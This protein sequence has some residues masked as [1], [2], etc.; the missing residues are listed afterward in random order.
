MF[1]KDITYTDFNGD[2]DVVL[3]ETLRFAYT[4]PAVRLYERETG[5]E[6]FRDYDGAVRAFSAAL[7][8]VDLGQLKKI[9]VSGGTLDA[10]NAGDI[11]EGIDYLQVLTN[12]EIN[13]FMLKLIPCL[14]AEAAGGVLV[15]NEETHDNAENAPWFM[16][17][18]NLEFFIEVFTELTAG[19]LPSVPRAKKRQQAKQRISC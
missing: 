6:F 3:Q 15:Q 16:A 12:P 7:K 10:D 13:E 5:R 1:R 4:L 14:Y 18:V 9:G 11:A 19:G 2:E 17:L 8:G